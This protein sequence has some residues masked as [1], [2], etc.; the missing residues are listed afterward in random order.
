MIAPMNIPSRRSLGRISSGP[1]GENGSGLS[2]NLDVKLGNAL[3]CDDV[4]LVAESLMVHGLTLPCRKP[5]GSSDRI[6]IDGDF[7]CLGEVDDQEFLPTHEITS[8]CHPSN[9]SPTAII[10][11]RLPRS[12]QVAEAEEVYSY[13]FHGR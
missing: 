13:Q 7:V 12:K 10:G 6:S 5:S 11:H 2:E 4:S 3:C 1:K 8:A 9:L